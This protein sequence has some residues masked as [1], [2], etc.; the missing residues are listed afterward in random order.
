MLEVEGWPELALT[1]H[2]VEARVSEVARHPEVRAVLRRV[3]RRLG[4]EGAVMEGR[5]IGSV[6]F[7]DA[8]VKLFLRAEADARAARRAAERIADR[9]STEAAV[10]A[11]DAADARTSPLVPAAGAVV[12]DTG[13][14]DVEGTLAAALAIVGER[15]PELLP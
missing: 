3:Q 7:P 10:E 9:A 11:R 12:I 1:T 4:E 6:V 5:D 14:L 2:E 15:A 8:P 13:T